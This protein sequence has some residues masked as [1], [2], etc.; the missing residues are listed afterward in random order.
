[1]NKGILVVE[2]FGEKFPENCTEFGSA[3]MG[4]WVNFGAQDLDSNDLD[5]DINNQIHIKI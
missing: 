5:M 2:I 3:R 4:T 1:L